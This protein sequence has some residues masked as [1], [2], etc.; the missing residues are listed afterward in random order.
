M[1]FIDVADNEPPSSQV[2][3]DRGGLGGLVAHT[4]LEDA[5]MVVRLMREGSRKFM[6]RS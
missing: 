2:C 1:Y 3:I 4:A 5:L 6:S